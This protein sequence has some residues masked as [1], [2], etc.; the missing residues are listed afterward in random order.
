[1]L[2]WCKHQ[3]PTEWGRTPTRSLLISLQ[4]MGNETACCKDLLTTPRPRRTS[5]ED[6]QHIALESGTRRVFFHRSPIATR[7]RG[8][9]ET[10]PNITDTPRTPA[11][12]YPTTNPNQA[13]GSREREGTKAG[14]P[15]N[16]CCPSTPGK[17]TIFRP[18]R[19]H[20]SRAALL[21]GPSHCFSL[22]LPAATLGPAAL[23]KPIENFSQ[24]L[25]IITQATFGYRLLSS[26]N[27]SAQ[28]CQFGNQIG[29]H[30]GD[31]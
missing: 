3:N 18:T 22:C 15:A 6:Q 20:V 5:A 23:S 12:H 31:W 26:G 11:Q 24:D 16:C 27:L 17:P 19:Q 21:W 8:T 4:T 28:L 10:K 2:A 14:L 30:V 7:P 29:P 13:D 25:H 1:M 9:T